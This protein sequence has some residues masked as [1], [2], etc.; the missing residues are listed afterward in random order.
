[1]YSVSIP[2]VEIALHDEKGNKR[3]LNLPNKGIYCTYKYD[4]RGNLI[5]ER[6]TRAKD[7]SSAGYKINSYDES[8][9]KIEEK[10]YSSAGVLDTRNIYKYNEKGELIQQ[11]IYTSDK[12]YSNIYYKYN[13]RGE[14]I[15]EK[16][17][18]SSIIINSTYKYKYDEKGNWINRIEFIDDKPKYIEERKYE[19]YD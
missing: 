5:E 19:Y 8:N 11:S 16:Y 1:M 2:K 12:L 15:E 6:I 7:G 4:E 13:N 9:N 18:Y 3:K 10:K 14:R 17:E